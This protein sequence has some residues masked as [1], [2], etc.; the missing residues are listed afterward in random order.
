MNLVTSDSLHLLRDRVDFV[1]VNVPPFDAINGDRPLPD[2]DLRLAE[3]TACF[4]MATFGLQL[5]ELRFAQSHDEALARGSK[6]FCL[7]QKFGHIFHGPQDIA[8]A[9]IEATEKCAFLMGHIMER[10]G[11]YFLHDQ[12]ALVNRR[13]WERLGRPSFGTPDS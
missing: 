8:A 11:Y 4:T 7:I 2:L 5:H 6:D 3:L 12:C 9:M 10:G 13:A 1:L